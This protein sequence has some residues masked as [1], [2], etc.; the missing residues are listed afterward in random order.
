VTA[1]RFVAEGGLIVSHRDD[2][3][4]VTY[5]VIRRAD[6]WSL[7]KGHRE[8]TEELLATA[9]RELLEEAGVRCTVTAPAGVFTYTTGDELRTVHYF[10]ARYLGPP[11]TPGRL[12]GVSQTLWLGREDAAALLTYPDLREFFLS[13]TSSAAQLR[14]GA[15]AVPRSVRRDARLD[16]LMT[17]IDVFELE[18]GAIRSMSEVPAGR[19][20][21]WR[22]TV[23]GLLE[24]AHEL[25]AARRI[26]AAWEALHSAQR[27]SLNELSTEECSDKAVARRTEVD[28]K[29]RGWRLDAAKALLGA[30]ASEVSAV[31]LG[32]ATRLLN[33]ESANTYL[34]LRL[35]GLGLKIAASLLTVI[36][37]LLGV[38]VGLD[39]FDG[40]VVDDEAFVLTDAGL[41]FGSVILGAFGAMLSL[42]L[43]NRGTSLVSMRIY[44]LATAQYVLP[45]ARLAIG[46]AS[47]VLLVAA[48]QSALADQGQAW[49]ILTA[50]PAGFSERLVRHSVE[51]LEIS[52]GGTSA[53][54]APG[55]P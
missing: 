41:F 9:V 24:R 14:P 25:G 15:R 53:A 1:L 49:A 32:E 30:D 21:A 18:L 26:D 34:K 27:L 8:G 12:D 51:S 7:P 11:T 22:P 2:E 44:E 20:S 54:N 48:T 36:L 35:G 13:V 19:A 37:V 31:R 16:R 45:I 52:A 5:L 55:R 43:D 17:A 3:G 50:I 10:H 47:G 4:R 29:L 6:D 46:G 40:L 28:R 39:S 42:A 23:D 33:E 38:A